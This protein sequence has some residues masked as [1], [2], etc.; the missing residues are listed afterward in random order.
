MQNLANKS[1]IYKFPGIHAHSEGRISSV[2]E[3]GLWIHLAQN[4]V[5]AAVT[6]PPTIKLPIM[7]IPFCQLQWMI[8]S[9]DP[10]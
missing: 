1:V 7:F 8:V 6:L 4:E 2:D 5:P 10:A 9:S 3:H